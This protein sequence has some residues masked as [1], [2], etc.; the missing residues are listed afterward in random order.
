MTPPATTPTDA[1]DVR[2]AAPADVMESVE[3]MR[4][5]AV[6][7]GHAAAFT[8]TPERLAD[9][10]FGPVPGLLCWVAADDGRILGVAL[11][12]TTWVG[13]SC[14]PSLRLLNLVVDDT[15]RR[16]GVGSRLMAAVAAKCVDLNC[17]LDWMVRTDNRPAQLFY[18]RHGAAPRDEWQSWQM[19]REALQELANT[20]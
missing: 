14:R 20:P 15:V 16:R 8:A 12:A 6:F 18:L 1:A 13:I 7:E 3:L 19:S 5:L 2:R 17:S 10:L 9:G 4:R 11:C